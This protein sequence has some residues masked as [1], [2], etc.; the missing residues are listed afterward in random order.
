M[1]NIFITGGTAPNF[2]KMDIE[3]GEREAILGARA[4]I[5]KYKP[6]L[7]VSAY[8]LPTDLW[9]LGLLIAE[10]DSNYQFFVRSHAYS[11]FET[12]LYAV[13]K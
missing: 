9:G 7:A 6:G 12:V 3:G 1:I 10:I 13:P 8:H 5:K 11:S 4:T 2:I